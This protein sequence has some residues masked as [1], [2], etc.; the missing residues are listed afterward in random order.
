MRYPRQEIVVTDITEIH[1]ERSLII[2]AEVVPHPKEGS[3]TAIS[4]ELPTNEKRTEPK[5]R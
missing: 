1:G 2:K 3:K 4:Q 5:T